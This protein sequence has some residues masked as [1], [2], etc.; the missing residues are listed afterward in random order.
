MENLLALMGLIMLFIVIVFV[1]YCECIIRRTKHKNKVHFYAARDKSGRLWLYIGKPI[2]GKGIFYVDYNNV[3]VLTNHNFNKF[4][5][6]EKDYDNLKWED[7]PIEV[8][9]NMK[10]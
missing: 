3:Y 4:G 2:R 1:L 9:L 6:N 7:K 8:F 5:L 10:D